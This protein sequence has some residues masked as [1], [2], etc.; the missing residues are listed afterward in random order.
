MASVSIA[1]I[2]AAVFT[3]VALTVVANVDTVAAITTVIAM[4]FVAT[5]FSVDVVMCPLSCSGCCG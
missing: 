4:V 5:M 2:A 3:I 1:A